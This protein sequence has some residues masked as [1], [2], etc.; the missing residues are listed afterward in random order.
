MKKYTSILLWCAVL[1]SAS[2]AWA[3]N[4]ATIKGTVTNQETGEV[5]PGVNVSLIG[6]TK[7]DATDASGQ[8]EITNVAAGTYQI[9]ASYLGYSTFRSEQ[10]IIEAGQTRTFDIELEETVRMG[11]EIVVSGTKQPEKL[12]ESPTT[13]ERVSQ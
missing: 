4:T 12:L 11:E 5:M 6:T 8:Y 3:Q 1:L 10:I 7:G 9:K 2:T 13:I